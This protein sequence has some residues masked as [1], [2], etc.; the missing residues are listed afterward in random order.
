[1]SCESV[2]IFSGTKIWYGVEQCSTR[3][4]KPWPKWGVGYTDWS[5]DC[6][7]CC[8]FIYKLCCLLFYCFKMNWEDS[9][10]E[11]LIQKFC[12]QFHLVRK[13][14][15]RKLVPVFGTDF[16]C[17]CLRHKAS[18]YWPEMAD[19]LCLVAVDDKSCWCNAQ[20]VVKASI[21]LQHITNTF[22]TT[23]KCWKSEFQPDAS[24]QLSIQHHLRYYSSCLHDVLSHFQHQRSVHA[25]TFPFV[26]VSRTFHDDYNT[27]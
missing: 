3:C 1:M 6:Q 15:T 22:T 10:I 14:G 16:W 27:A 21:A 24:K 23:Q 18:S 13:T 5:D 7:L 26:A 19:D 9:S 8:L 20:Q 17:V 2:S 25:E 4:R 12:F 11:K